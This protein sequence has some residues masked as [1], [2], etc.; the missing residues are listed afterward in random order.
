[1]SYSLNPASLVQL[2]DTVQNG[3]LHRPDAG[4]VRREVA[5]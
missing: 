2:A 3:K 4:K 5:H 1:M